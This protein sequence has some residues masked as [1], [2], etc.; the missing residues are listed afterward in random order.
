MDSYKEANNSMD[1][2][3]SLTRERRT[4]KIDLKFYRSLIRSPI[5]ITNTRSNICFIIDNMN[6]YMD[7]PKEMHLEANK[8]ILR[9]FKN[10]QFCLRSQRSLYPFADV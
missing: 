1:P 9:Y 10:L 7:K 3:C 5:Y 2:S 4:S 6:K 8:Q